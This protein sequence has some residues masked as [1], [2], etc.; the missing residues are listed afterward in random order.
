MVIAI[1]AIPI[2][3]NI[4]LEITTI[5]GTENAGS[6][7]PRVSGYWEKNSVPKRPQEAGSGSRLSA[8]STGM[9]IKSST[10]C[11]CSAAIPNPKAKISDGSM[12]NSVGKKN[13][14]TD[15]EE[16]NRYIRNPI[17]NPIEQKASRSQA[18]THA[19]H[20]TIRYVP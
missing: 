2:A 12:V 6:C 17:P 8:S 13:A 10:G 11:A 7:M 19:P 15:T 5:V 16:P 20:F 4:I 9:R 14:P 1:K 3:E 18:V